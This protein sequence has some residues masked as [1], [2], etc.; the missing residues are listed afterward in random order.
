MVY[1][2]PENPLSHTG[3]IVISNVPTDV[4]LK[5]KAGNCQDVGIFPSVNAV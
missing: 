5:G 2:T 4:G 1:G 3:V